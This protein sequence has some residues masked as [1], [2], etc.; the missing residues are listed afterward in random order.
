[1]VLLRFHDTVKA[2]RTIPVLDFVAIMKRGISGC[3]C[4]EHV[5]H[6]RGN[7]DY[8]ANKVEHPRT[9]KPDTKNL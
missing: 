4:V 8:T 7:K 9:E 3:I 6:V 2:M 5:V 1:M